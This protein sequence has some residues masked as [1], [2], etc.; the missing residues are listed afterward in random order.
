MGTEIE[1][2]FLVVN[3]AWKAHVQKSSSCRQGYLNI[4]GKGSVRIRV[5]GDQGYLTLKGPR[6]GIRRAE[7]EYPIPQAEATELLELFCDHTL[8][9][10]TRHDVSFA[11]KLWEVDE[12]EAENAGLTLAEVELEKEDESFELPDWVGRDISTDHRFFNAS[13]AKHPF[14]EWQPDNR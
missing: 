5:F 3:N 11:G 1:R 7:F 12:F 2:K 13:L 6:T 14:S 4:R 10:K 8:I 9:V